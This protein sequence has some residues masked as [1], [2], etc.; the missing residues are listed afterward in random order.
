MSKVK[1]IVLCKFKDGTS[2]EQITKF[3]DDFL[4][5]SETVPGIEDYVAGANSSPEGRD[6]G[7]THGVIMTFADATARDAYRANADYQRFREMAL[8]MLGDVL[9]LDFEV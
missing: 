7:M 3:F 6:H 9:V 8:A 5:L 1:H 4:D 2:E